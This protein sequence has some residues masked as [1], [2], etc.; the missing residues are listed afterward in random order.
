MHALVNPRI[1]IKMDLWGHLTQIPISGSLLGTESFL[2]TRH[3]PQLLN[4]R[5]RPSLDGAC[6]RQTLPMHPFSST[7]P[8]TDMFILLHKMLLILP[9]FRLHNSSFIYHTSYEMRQFFYHPGHFALASQVY[10]SEHKM[11]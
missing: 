4:F 10:D 7:S 8:A 2:L 9:F 11:N 6:P 5:G 1:L 3:I